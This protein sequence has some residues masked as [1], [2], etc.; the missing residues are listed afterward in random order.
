VENKYPGAKISLDNSDIKWIQEN[1]V[2]GDPINVGSFQLRT[3]VY[4]FDKEY[5]ISQTRENFDSFLKG[6]NIKYDKTFDDVVLDDL[7]IT[8]CY[9]PPITLLRKKKL[10]QI[11]NEMDM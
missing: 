5:L 8:I 1:I 7:K 6:W 11:L 2:Y 9:N 4:L 10:K 3:P